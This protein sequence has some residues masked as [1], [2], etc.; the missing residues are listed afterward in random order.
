MGL[1]LKDLQLFI[2]QAQAHGVIGRLAPATLAAWQEAVDR[3]GFDADY[4]RLIQHLEAD[5]G[6]QVRSRKPASHS[7]GG[8]T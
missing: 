4:S 8:T 6:V 2:D 7:S 3:T 5:A 1:M